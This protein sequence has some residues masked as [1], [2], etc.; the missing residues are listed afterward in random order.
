MTKW[1]LSFSFCLTSFSMKISRSIH[2]SANGITSS[3]L[4]L[5]SISSGFPGGSDGKESACN[6]G[7]LWVWSLGWKDPLEEG[8][9]THPSILAWQRRVFLH[10]RGEYSCMSI[11]ASSWT[12]EPGRTPGGYKESDLTEQLNTVQKLLRR[13]CWFNGNTVDEVL[14]LWQ[15]SYFLL[16][17][18]EYVLTKAL[19]TLQLVSHIRM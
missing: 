1:Y 5:N 11:H 10:D 18:F 6:V 13:N 8:M 2:V 17:N 14:Y 15:K 19:G 4:W 9:A 7:D 12:E 3:Y 16:K